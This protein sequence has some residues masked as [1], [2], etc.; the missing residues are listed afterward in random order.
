MENNN[1]TYAIISL[2]FGVLGLF[3]FGIPFGVAALAF[4]YADKEHHGMSIGGMILGVI[5]VLIPLFYIIANY[6]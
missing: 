4:G 6:Y 2:M 5:D 3:L 1:K